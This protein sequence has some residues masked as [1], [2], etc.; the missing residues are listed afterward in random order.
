[1]P[2][3]RIEISVTKEM[4]ARLERCARDNGRSVPH[5]VVRRLA[6]TLLGENRARLAKVAII[7]GSLLEA[8]AYARRCGYGRDEWFYAHSIESATGRYIRRI[9]TTGTYRRRHRRRLDALMEK[10]R[11]G[12]M[13][14][15]TA[16]AQ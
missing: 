12:E 15:K 2:M 7:A 9:E 16:M 11:D 1:M 3:P 5:E 8:K 13:A 10:L 6:W 4:L 14:A